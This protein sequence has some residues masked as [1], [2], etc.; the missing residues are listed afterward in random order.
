MSEFKTWANL[1]PDTPFSHLFPDG[2]VPIVSPLPIIPREVGSP[3]CY[4]VSGSLLTDGQLRE[5]AELLWQRWQPE[6]E[7][8]EQA[9]DY[10]RQNALP[11]RTDWFTSFMSVDQGL[12]LSLVEMGEELKRSNSKPDD[13]SDLDPI[14]WIDG[15]PIYREAIDHDNA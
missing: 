4:L 6:C 9:I 5:L 2:R 3:P 13:D 15:E 7:S 11:L 8:L 1:K 10:I 12:M 14:G